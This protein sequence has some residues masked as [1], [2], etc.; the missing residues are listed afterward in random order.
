MEDAL[1]RNKRN[2]PEEYLCFEE[3]ALEK[4][5]Y[6]DGTITQRAAV[7]LQH[8]IISGN[9]LMALG[10]ALDDQDCVAVGSD[11]KVGIAA[12]DSYVY[13]DGMVICGKPEYADDRRDIVKNPVLIIEVLSESTESYDR[14]R[15]FK[16]Y[17]SLPS[18]REYVLVSQTEPI[19]ETYFRQDDQHRLYSLTE[20]LEA[21][22]QLH[23]I[24]SR[25]RLSEV[26]QRVDWAS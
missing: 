14:G 2:T 8:A 20:G 3:T 9:M 12:Y 5:E 22:I 4:H 17:Q 13:T 15:K 24:D 16:K 26:Y 10:K 6:E 25:I 11:L 7:T 19:I 23:T 1:I 18:F 21:G